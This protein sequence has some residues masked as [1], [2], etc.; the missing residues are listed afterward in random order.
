MANINYVICLSASQIGFLAKTATKLN[1]AI[2][3]VV[4]LNKLYIAILLSKSFL[5]FS[6]N[7]MIVFDLKNNKIFYI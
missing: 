5:I 4:I 1:I 6:Y 7:N 2:N 3:T